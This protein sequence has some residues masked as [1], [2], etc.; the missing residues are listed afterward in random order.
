MKLDDDNRLIIFSS[1]A[2]I[3][4]L[5]LLLISL[6]VITRQTAFGLFLPAAVLVVV[7]LIASLFTANPNELPELSQSKDI[8]IHDFDSSEVETVIRVRHLP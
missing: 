5:P 7:Y 2:I 4:L 1:L 3:T 6:G 8:G